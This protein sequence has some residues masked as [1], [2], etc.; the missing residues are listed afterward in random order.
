MYVCMYEY[1][2]VRH[3]RR[4]VEGLEGV[5]ADLGG[6]VEAGLGEVELL[7]PHL[8]HGDVVESLSVLRVH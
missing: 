2:S 4:V 6:R 5:R 8:Q 1:H 3:E 7:Q